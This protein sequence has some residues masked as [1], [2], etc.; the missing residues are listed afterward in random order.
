MQIEQ[1][2]LVPSIKVAL[3]L[4]ISL[5][6]QQFF[7]TGS[8]EYTFLIYLSMLHSST[9]NRTSLPYIIRSISTQNIFLVSCIWSVAYF[10]V[11]DQ[12][13]LNEYFYSFFRIFLILYSLNS[14]LDSSKIACFNK[15]TDLAVWGRRTLLLIN[16]LMSAWSGRLTSAASD[17]LFIPTSRCFTFL[18]KF[19][20]LDIDSL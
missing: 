18:I 16:D 20:L 15:P 4:K 1:G 6:I 3:F 10:F 5:I 9:L 13:F 19:W 14:Q 12:P 7:P 8:Q 17:Y 11:L 2:V